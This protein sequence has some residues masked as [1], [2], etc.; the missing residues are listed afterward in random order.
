G[1]SKNCSENRRMG[2]F[3]AVWNG[4]SPPHLCGIGKRL[5]HRSPPP[6][7]SEG[8]GMTPV[9]A[10][11]MAA[12]A[13]TRLRPLTHDIPKPM[14]SVLNRPGLEYMIQNLKRHGITEIILNLHNFPEQIQR[15]FGNGTRWG[16]RL[17]YSYEPKL[18][19]TA[20]GVGKAGW[21]L[22]QGTFL[23]TSG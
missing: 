4:T 9:R 18:L 1:W 12:G 11:V 20:G 7:G 22:K 3:A 15:H 13:G 16:V 23:V 14:G 10:M 5:P 17:A 6:L 21:F 19:G 2:S 8:S